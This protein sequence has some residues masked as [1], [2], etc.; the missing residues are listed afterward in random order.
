MGKYNKF[1]HY[2]KLYIW[3]FICVS[4]S[5]KDIIKAKLTDFSFFWQNNNYL[6]YPR[7]FMSN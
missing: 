2:N 4:I 7:K 6:W 3:S 1:N 5:N